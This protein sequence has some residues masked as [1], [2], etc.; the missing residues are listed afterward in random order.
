MCA[1]GPVAPRLLDDAAG[2]PVERL[3][4][5]VRD[6]IRATVD[7]PRAAGVLAALAIGD[8]SAI[9]RDDWQLFRDS[10]IAHLVAISGL[11]VTMFAWLAAG[12]I[13]CGWRRSGARTAVA[14]GAAGRP[15]R[16][17]G[18]G[19][20]LCAGRRL[21][22]AGAAHGADA[23]AGRAAR[24]HRPSL[25]VADGAGCGGGRGHRLRSRGPCCSPASGCRSSRSGCCS[26]AEPGARARPVGA[27]LGPAS[28]RLAARGATRWR[29]AAGNCCAAR[30]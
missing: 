22:R 14:A 2:H 29:A 6:A 20:R 13:G 17:R 24:Q 15:L 28:D 4:H 3:R 9:D 1:N 10:G 7:D 25:A 19:R 12:L 26:P 21:G 30:R 5:A 27:A 18:R 23:G 11:H 8:Q 16:R